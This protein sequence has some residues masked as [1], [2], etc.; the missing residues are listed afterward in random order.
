MRLI[1]NVKSQ[2]SEGFYEGNILNSFDEV[3][4]FDASM[5]KFFKYNE[6]DEKSI[7]F[8]YKGAPLKDME[9]EAKKIYTFM[10]YNVGLRVV[11][12]TIDF[13]RTENKVWF[14]NLKSYELEE[15]AREMKKTFLLMNEQDILNNRL[16]QKEKAENTGKFIY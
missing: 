13:M 7:K 15:Q 12:L 14:L 16:T 2:L 8:K 3:K 4:S 6:S 10:L 11:K 9:N 1:Y 5:H